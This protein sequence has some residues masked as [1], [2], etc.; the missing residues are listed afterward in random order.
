MSPW[1]PPHVNGVV[2]LE[3]KLESDDALVAR[4]IRGDRDA[5]GA[6]YR[7][8]RRGLYGYALSLSNDE[9]RAGDA[10]QELW[11]GFLRDIE[12]LAA[13]DNV[14]AYLYRTLR[15]RLI[16]EFRRRQR[17]RKALDERTEPMVVVR[18]RDKAVTREEA[19][20][21]SDAIASLPDE[22][23]EVVLLRVYGDMSFAHIAEVTNENVKTVESR[24]RLALEKLRK[25]LKDA[26]G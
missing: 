16:D 11:L 9:A 23:R 24:H 26:R 25:R 13:A 1:A 2:A 22:Q 4:F 6:L 21:V 19:A 14:R 17:E 12:K 5:F 8:H 10:V 7:R 18:P 15:N 3:T 20:R